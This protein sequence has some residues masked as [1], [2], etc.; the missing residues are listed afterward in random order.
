MSFRRTA[1]ISIGVAVIVVVVASA[2]LVP[3]SQLRSCGHSHSFSSYLS[4]LTHTRLASTHCCNAY[5]MIADLRAIDGAMELYRIERGKPATAFDQLTND[6]VRPLSYDF[7]LVSDG[8]RWSVAV[9]PQ[10][11]FPGHYLFTSEYR[12][13]FSTTGP[14]TT[15][16]L[17]LMSL[18]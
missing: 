5:S 14:A 1:L 4:K 2:F 10:G 17:D 11:A 12:L 16:D 18:R 9:P 7:T 6:Y 15:N 3:R 13:H 8:Q